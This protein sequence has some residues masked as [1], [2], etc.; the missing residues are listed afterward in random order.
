MPLPK[1]IARF[2]KCLPHKHGDL[3][4]VYSTHIQ[5]H[6]VGAEAGGSLEISDN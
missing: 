1:K 6:T 3:S 2:V 4:S 5:N